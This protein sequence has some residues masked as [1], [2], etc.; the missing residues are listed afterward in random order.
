MVA[1]PG[2]RYNGFCSDISVGV[3]RACRG[4]ASKQEDERG[5]ITPHDENVKM[6]W[7]DS[8]ET[9]VNWASSLLVLIQLLG[10]LVVMDRKPLQ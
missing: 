2:C 10:R 4:P 6:D 5:R 7:I 3:D 1:G 8:D 9:V